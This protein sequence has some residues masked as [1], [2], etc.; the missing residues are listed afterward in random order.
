[1][2]PKYYRIKNWELFQHY[3]D[4][5]PPWIKLYRSIL[6]DKEWHKIDALSAKVLIM[7]WLIAS[8]YN[9]C[10]PDIESLSFRLRLSKLDIERCISELNHWIVE[11]DSEMLSKCLPNA[12]PETEKRQRQRQN[13]PHSE[14][15]KKFWK[16]YPRKIG[17]QDAHEKWLAAIKGYPPED[18]IAAASEYARQCKREKTEDRF[19]K[20]PSTFLNKERWK[21]Y[22]LEA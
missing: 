20:H 3:K 17:K 19:I 11:I 16:E 14:E 12:L 2:E 5:Y 7:L 8:E 13:I 18:I 1:M 6:D 10:L 4:R 9:G 21:D 15:F 22:C